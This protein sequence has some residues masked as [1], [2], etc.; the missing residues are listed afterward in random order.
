[1]EKL[2]KWAQGVRILFGFEAASI[3]LIG[4]SYSINLKSYYLMLYAA[5]V[6]AGILIITYSFAAWM[7]NCADNS[8]RIKKANIQ[9]DVAVSLLGRIAE[10]QKQDD[11]SAPDAPKNRPV[12]PLKEAVYPAHDGDKIICPKCGERQPAN[13][14]VCFNC[15]TPFKK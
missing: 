3:V 15:A 13:R 12:H 2:R 7:D 9:I 5:L 10:A 11:Q 8:E 14:I 6:A 4:L 1:M